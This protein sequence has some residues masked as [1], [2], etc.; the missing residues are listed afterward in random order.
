MTRT[1]RDAAICLGALTGVDSLDDKTL[2]SKGK[3]LKDYTQFLKE[4]GLKGKRIGFYKPAVVSNYKVTALMLKAVE[5]MK[6]KGAEIIELDKIS[7]DN[8]ERYEYQVMLY[9]YKDGLNKYFKS[10]G[11]KAPI[12]NVE[13]LIEFNKKDTVELRYFNQIWLEMAQ[14]KGDLTSQ[15]Y[16]ESLTRSLNGSR[17]NGID[18]V[19]NQYHLDAIIG[20]AAGPAPKTDLTNGGRSEVGSSSFAA[21]AGYP[22]ITLPMGEIDGLPVGISFFGRAW[23]EP[24]LLEITYAFEQGTK[25]RIIPTYRSF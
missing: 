14:Q 9:E 13:E 23:S 16:V 19:M 22:N 8:L 24:L 7:E 5:F 1:V 6:S 15:E 21:R 2:E 3:S 25:H 18:K 12:K 17:E 4:D 20:P 11:P 10:L